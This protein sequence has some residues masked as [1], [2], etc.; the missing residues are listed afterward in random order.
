MSGSEAISA[1]SKTQPI[2]QGCPS[3]DPTVAA[4][5][6]LSTDPA[7]PTHDSGIAQLRLCHLHQCPTPSST[8][9]LTLCAW[10]TCIYLMES[11]SHGCSSCKGGC[12]VEFW[13]SPLERREGL[14]MPYFLQYKRD[15]PNMTHVHRPFQI[16]LLTTWPFPPQCFSHC[17]WLGGYAISCHQTF[18]Q[19]S[20]FA[21]DARLTPLWQR[22][23]QAQ[24][25]PFPGGLPWPCRSQDG[26]ITETCM[27]S[28][29]APEAKCSPSAGTPQWIPCP[30]FFALPSGPRAGF[31]YFHFFLF[32]SQ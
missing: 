20:L 22:H 4:A 19:S 5:A 12:Q 6:V 29:G 3:E 28:H 32:M 30:F 17:E 27:D 15:G 18:K 10:N 31:Y 23:P 21:W 7:F 25:T 2:P 8:A 26:I 14:I 24:L 16:P 11:M 9:I 1:R 13:P